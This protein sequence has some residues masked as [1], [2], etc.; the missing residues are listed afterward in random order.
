MENGFY[1]FLSLFLFFFCH[2]CFMAAKTEFVVSTVQV[3]CRKLWNL[4]CNLMAWIIIK[5][6]C[7]PPFLSFSRRKK[8]VYAT[9]WPQNNNNEKAPFTASA[10]TP[11]LKMLRFG[12]AS[13]PAACAWV[14]ALIRD[15]LV[16]GRKQKVKRKEKKWDGDHLVEIQ[17]HIASYPFWTQESCYVDLKKLWGTKS[18]CVHLRV[19]LLAYTKHYFSVLTENRMSSSLIQYG[20]TPDIS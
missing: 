5:I 13:A 1:Y 18:V 6:F 8:I 9:F 20:V 16:Q 11:T 4:L 17:S 2:E 12:K 19:F 3:W 15:Y 10:P 14:P 7:F